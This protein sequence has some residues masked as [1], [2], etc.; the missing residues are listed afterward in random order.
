MSDMEQEAEAPMSD[1]EEIRRALLNASGAYEALKNMPRQWRQYF[2]GLE[3]CEATRLEALA[4]LDR[5]YTRIA[6]LEQ[7]LTALLVGRM[8]DHTKEFGAL[9]NDVTEAC[10]RE[11]N[12]LRDALRSGDGEELKAVT[13]LK[14][15]AVERIERFVSDM[16]AR[17]AALE[18]GLYQIQWRAQLRSDTTSRD[19]CLICEALLAPE[20]TPPEAKEDNG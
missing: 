15:Q 14:E 5:V 20:A 12:A 4:A 11:T 7:A 13:H 19:I 16:D 2:P 17:I 3:G 10:C 1:L 8:S 9:L 6:A 18:A